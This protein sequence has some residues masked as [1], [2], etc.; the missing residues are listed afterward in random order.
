[1]NAGIRPARSGDL[2]RLLEE[3]AQ[4]PFEFARHGATRGL[5]LETEE[6][7]AVVFDGAANGMR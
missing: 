5:H 1:V 2:H 7:R 4:A 6:R 3:L